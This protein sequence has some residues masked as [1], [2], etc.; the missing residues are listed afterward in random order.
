MAWKL[1]LYEAGLIF[2]LLAQPQSLH[3]QSSHQQQQKTDV[4]F[5]I[6]GFG[7][8]AI[9]NNSWDFVVAM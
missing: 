3:T 6:H 7:V 2:R 4:Q 1:T 8:P 9:E 5:N